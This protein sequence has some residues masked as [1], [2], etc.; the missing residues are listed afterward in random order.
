MDE[1]DEEFDDMKRTPSKTKNE[2]RACPKCFARFGEVDELREQV[3][4]LYN[5]EDVARNYDKSRELERARC[6]QIIEDHVPHD[7]Y[8]SMN[9]CTG[10]Q[11]IDELKA[12]INA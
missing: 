3:Q 9:N 2:F 1:P 4:R 12:R 7:G 5:D 10:C 8:C 6:V 11:I